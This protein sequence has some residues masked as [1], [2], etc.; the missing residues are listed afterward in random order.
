MPHLATDRQPVT[1]LRVLVVEDS[2]FYRS[3]LTRLLQQD[4]DIVVVGEAGDGREAIAK[5]QALRPDVVTMDVEMPVLDGIAAVREIMRIAPTSILMLSALTRVGAD[6]TFA[7][8]EAG[9]ADFLPKHALQ[10]DD[11]GVTARALRARVRDLGREGVRA[12]SRPPVDV[13]ALASS[14]F[15]ARALLVIGASTGGPALVSELLA[16]CS[17][18]LPC[19][20]LVV[21]HMPAG[22]TAYFAERVDRQCAL[23]V[24]EASDGAAL[25]PGRI[26]IAPGGHQ[27]TVRRGARLELA[28]READGAESYRPCIDLTLDSV[29]RAC[30][31]RAIAYIATGMGTDGAAGS[32]A[33]HAAGGEVWAQDAAGCVVFGMPAAVIRAG[34]ADEVVSAT[35]L[36]R[37]LRQ[38]P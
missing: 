23:T 3:Q 13:P 37:R 6:A 18:Q 24:A 36:G 8:L 17:A 7:A 31:N 11:S 19:A 34:V 32:R 2:L 21:M 26:W 22:F 12:V 4:G 27:T 28:V 33:L 9:A 15:A 29:A 1:P 35:E 30:G 16:A 25:V 20:V 10:G 5:A 38:G 14:C